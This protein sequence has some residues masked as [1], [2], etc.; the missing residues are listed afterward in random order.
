MAPQDYSVVLQT[1]LIL[2]FWL[3]LEYCQW[4]V[5]LH[6]NLSKVIAKI[7]CEFCFGHNMIFYRIGATNSN[8]FVLDI[9]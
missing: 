8:C 1:T 7:I 3:Y 9:I 2:N 6:M 4:R 5:H